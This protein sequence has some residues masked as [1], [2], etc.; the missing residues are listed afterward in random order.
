MLQ[1]YIHF[2]FF[3][4]RRTS[5]KVCRIGRVQHFLATESVANSVPLK[6]NEECK[7][8]SRESVH[9]SPNLADNDDNTS[10]SLSLSLSLSLSQPAHL[11][12][13]ILSSA[14]KMFPRSRSAVY[15]R[16]FDH[17]NAHRN[18]GTRNHPP[19]CNREYQALSR[20]VLIFDL[21]TTRHLSGRTKSEYIVCLGVYPDQQ[22]GPFKTRIPCDIMI[23]R[24]KRTKHLSEANWSTADAN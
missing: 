15:I 16:V 2:Q 22:S 19:G 24:K 10:V 3:D 5:T 9:S 18:P 14:N 13:N 23:E 21:H 12:H 17:A 6:R 7:F 11:A 20:L 8:R 1:P 4:Q